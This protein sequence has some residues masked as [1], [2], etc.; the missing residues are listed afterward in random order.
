[1]KRI[2]VIATI[3]LVC[4][5]ALSQRPSDPTLLIMQEGPALNYN[6]VPHGLTLPEGMT[7]GL[8][9]DLEFDS[10]GHLWIMS[11][12]GAQNNIQPIV[13]FDENGKYI[14]SFGMG[15]FGNRPHGI[16]IDAE[17]NIW[18]SDGSNHTVVKFNPKGEVLLT[19]G[20]R[21][22]AGEWN[23]AAGTR[24]LN[25]P[26]DVA[27]GRNGDIFLV[28]GH[29]PGAMG[30]PRV[31]KFD[32]TGKFIKTW[33]GK[34]SD[35]GKFQVGHGIAVD[36][37][38]M[39]WVADR[40]NSRIQ[41]FDQDGNFVRQ[42]KYAGLPCSFLIRKD[43]ITMVNGFTG[44]ILELDLEGKVLGVYGKMGEFGEAHNVA[45]SPKGEIFVGDVTKGILKFVKK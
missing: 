2:A 12:P 22:Q 7:M 29:T 24:L 31:L 19:L 10:K 34:G 27:I 20:T 6:P 26:N 40:E 38:G 3:L 21:N 32:K 15:L 43:G 14:R 41:V 4:A 37:K 5:T 23:E 9:G 39:L 18:A 45:V 13:E 28:Q 17:G 11:R 1:M 36:A 42:M 33:G 8:P 30:D 16:H 44:Q 35:P 25:Q